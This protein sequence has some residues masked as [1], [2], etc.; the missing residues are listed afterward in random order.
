[1]YSEFGE[2]VDC[3]VLGDHMLFPR[4][5]SV[6]VIQQSGLFDPLLDQFVRVRRLGD[7]LFSGLL[8]VCTELFWRAAI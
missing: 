3:F 7:L 5:L 2:S 1:V 8:S 4:R 6:R